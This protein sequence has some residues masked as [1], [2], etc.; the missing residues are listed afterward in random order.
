MKRKKLKIGLTV[1]QAEVLIEIVDFVVQ[2]HG[3]F[4]TTREIREICGMK[5]TSTAR[6]YIDLLIEAGFL[7]A[8]PSYTGNQ[9]R[10]Y[11]IGI[12]IVHP[13]WYLH[14]LNQYY[15]E[16]EPETA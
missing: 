13:E 10:Y 12:P 4:P 9:K 8:R 7:G 1:R 15:R 5:S 3:G 6:H 14:L 11:V 16:I 2:N